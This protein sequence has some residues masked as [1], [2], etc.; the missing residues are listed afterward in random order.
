MGLEA[1]KESAVAMAKNRLEKAICA[2]REEFNTLRNR[3]APV[4]QPRPEDAVK[5]VSGPAAIPLVAELDKL[6]AM[7][8]ALYQLVR[9]TNEELE[10]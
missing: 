8:D 4:L 1:K 7:V 6:H 9:S 2:A 3:L 5:T 10:L